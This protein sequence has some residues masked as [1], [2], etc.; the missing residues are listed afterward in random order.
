MDAT[1][2]GDPFYDALV[3]FYSN[4][5]PYKI[6]DN[7][8]KTSLVTTLQLGF[9]H[10]DIKLPD[11]FVQRNTVGELESE[12]RTFTLKVTPSG[13]TQYMAKEGYHDD[14]VMSLALCYYLIRSGYGMVGLRDIWEKGYEKYI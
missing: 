2:V 1:G 9:D 12:L 8:L 6:T 13:V 7:N 3:Q 14:C 11:P 10:G 4:I 5:Q